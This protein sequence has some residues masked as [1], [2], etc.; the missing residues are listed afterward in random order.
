MS[1]DDKKQQTERSRLFSSE[2]FGMRSRKTENGTLASLKRLIRDYIKSASVEV[3]KGSK[4]SKLVIWIKRSFF[5]KSANFSKISI[6]GWKKFK[7]RLNNDWR[8]LFDNR[9]MKNILQKK[10][11][12]ESRQRIDL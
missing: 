11:N 12:L 4:M 7:K 3:K 10:N 9:F 1:V 2:V 5:K 6:G 8:I